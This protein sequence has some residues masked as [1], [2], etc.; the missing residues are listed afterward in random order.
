MK[1]V[2][3][4]KGLVADPIKA[5]EIFRA[6]ISKTLDLARMLVAG[7]VKVRTPLNTGNLR[8]SVSSFRADYAGGMAAIISSP[9]EYAAPV[10]YG[11]QPHWAPIEPLKLWALR[12]FRDESIAYPVRA[13]IAKRGTAPHWMFRLGLLAAKPKII[14]EFNR[15]VRGI[16]T[17]WEG[18]GSR[19]VSR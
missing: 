10:E 19:I 9:K 4:L 5:A 11:T 12:K 1:I 14:E 17:A 7:E 3:E 18:I 15:A 16:T 8:G 2:V 13:A 6:E